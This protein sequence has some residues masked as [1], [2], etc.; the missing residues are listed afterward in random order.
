MAKTEIVRKRQLAQALAE[1]AGLKLKTA[2][3]TVEFLFDEVA[4]QVVNGVKVNI[5]DFGIFVRAERK[6][7]MGRNP[8]TGE[9]LKIA[10][11]TKPR[12]SAS[13]TLKESIKAKK[14]VPHYDAEALCSCCSGKK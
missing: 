12:F 13:R 6:A 8:A 10:A 7:R 4:T 11:S 3:A 5:K 14:Y 2:L 9:P 1:K